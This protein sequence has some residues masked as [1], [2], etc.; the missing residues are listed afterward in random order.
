MKYGVIGFPIEHSRS[1]EIHH[2]FAN[3]F[4]LEITFTKH[5]VRK[6]ECSSWVKDFF[7]N[8]GIGLSVTLPLKEEAFKLADVI[9]D[10]ALQA[11]A[12]NM[13]HLKE[14]KI[15]ADCT[16]G[17]GLVNDLKVKEIELQAKNVLVIGAGGASRGII[18]SIL[19]ENPQQLI[20]ANR[21]AEKAYKLVAEIQ[22]LSGF[23]MKSSILM[24]SSLTLDNIANTSFDLV[25]NATSISTSPES[26]LEINSEI[27]KEAAVAL[28]LYYSQKDTLFMKM[29]KDQSVPE[30]FDGWGMLVQQAAESFSQWTGL[31]PDT[32]ELI[33][34][35][36]A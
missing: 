26:K 4:D 32:S 18:P 23:H 1:P 8:E 35:R 9:S 31:E 13:L 10:R 21:T 24:P 17:V 16:D 22:S 7:N 6:H 36:G 28:D 29:A 14:D 33:R 20:V 3:Q 19:S 11:G 12:A 15:F 2:S 30:V 27:F 25:I 5:L 34:S